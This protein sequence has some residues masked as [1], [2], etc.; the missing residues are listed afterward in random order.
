MLT[1]SNKITTH[2]CILILQCQL[3]LLSLSLSHFSSLSLSFSL[4]HTRSLSPSQVSHLEK[5]VAELENDNLM[6]GDLKS[7]LKQEN[8]QLVHK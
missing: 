7:K 4:S 3:I 8:T 5:K 1:V 2:G 6:S